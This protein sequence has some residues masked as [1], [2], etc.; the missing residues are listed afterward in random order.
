MDTP[1]VEVLSR[2]DWAA[3]KR[4]ALATAW[5]FDG[6]GLPSQL[7]RRKILRA[8]HSPIRALVFEIQLRDIPYWVSVHLVRHKIGVE[9]FV[10][11]QRDDR[12]ENEKPR[13]EMPQG[14]LVNHK[15]IANADALIAMSKKR[16]CALASPETRAV[17]NA[18]CL[19]IRKVDP[20]M[21][22]AMRPECWWCGNQCPEMKGCG[23]HQPLHEYETL[24]GCD[25]LA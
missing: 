8:R 13:A 4:A 7:W 16:R 18:V 22:W 14:A 20:D 10:S 19:A 1:K 23:K 24:K 17:W 9:H 21:F 6:D 5:K 12:H 25:T 3:V 11:S 2:G 15:L